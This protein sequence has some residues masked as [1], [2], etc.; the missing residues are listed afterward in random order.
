MAYTAA[1]LYNLTGLP[2]GDAVYRYDAGSDSMAT[3]AASGYFNNTDDD[4]NFAADDVIK[5]LCTDGDMDLR[6]SAVS[7]GT[8]TTQVSSGMAWNGV[9]G[10]ASGELTIGMNEIGT[11]TASA[12]ILQTP[13]V[14][15]EYIISKAGTG[16]AGETFVTDATAVSLNGAGDRTVT[17]NQKGQV[18]GLKAVSTT[19]WVI[20][21]G[22]ALVTSA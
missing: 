9:G 3:V 12:F 2:S 8:V 7:S 21:K 14:G 1:N 18:L 19:R 22:D 4:A 10:A 5:C 17:M 16:T 11:G 20:T 13:Y 15:A 6:V